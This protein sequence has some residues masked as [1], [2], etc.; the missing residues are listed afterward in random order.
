M[1][2]PTIHYL[3]QINKITKLYILVLTLYSKKTE[4]E[5]QVTIL[6]RIK[7][8]VKNQY[9]QQQTKE[10]FKL[11]STFNS[12][13]LKE[14]IFSNLYVFGLESG[15][16]IVTRYLS[17]GYGTSNVHRFDLCRR[18][19]EL[20]HSIGICISCVSHIPQPYCKA[21]FF[22]ELLLH[23]L[24]YAFSFSISFKLLLTLVS[25]SNTDR[26]SLCTYVTTSSHYIVFYVRVL[27]EKFRV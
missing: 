13:F 4:H 8:S 9:I 7:T 21:A 10:N 5:F 18:E 27:M 15:I 6:Y 25:S 1:L 2:K 24:H 23:I 26:N 3:K 22:Y 11:L 12:Y 17:R 14:L 19:Y 16:W 20:H